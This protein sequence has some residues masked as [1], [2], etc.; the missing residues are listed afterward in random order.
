MLVISVSGVS[1]SV[2]ALV[3]IVSGISR[4]VR[5][6]VISISGVS[7]LHV[8]IE[9]C[10]ALINFSVGVQIDPSNKDNSNNI[11]NKNTNKQNPNSIKTN[12]TT[13]DI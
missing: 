1:Q 6:L 13:V 11:D 7:H 12:Y 4:S 5:V 10:V 2:R 9:R 3:I 8:D